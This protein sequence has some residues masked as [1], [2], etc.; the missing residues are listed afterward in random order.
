MKKIEISRA[1]AIWRYYE[2]L[3]SWRGSRSARDDKNLNL[4]TFVRRIAFWSIYLA[5]KLV[6]VL[7]LVLFFI[8]S[9]L[10][11]VYWPIAHGW[12]SPQGHTLAGFVMV[13]TMLWGVVAV[14]A[15]IV[16]GSYFSEAVKRRASDNKDEKQNLL[17][18]WLRAK[19]EKFCPLIEVKE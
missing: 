1:S 18:A 7:A 6:F 13:G 15:G 2:F 14:A 19:K 5:V 8:G 10:I 9:M 4:C 12:I 16:F 3:D 17:L 11:A